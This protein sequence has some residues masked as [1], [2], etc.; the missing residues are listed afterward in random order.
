MLGYIWMKRLRLFGRHH[1]KGKPFPFV[2]VFS[3]LLNLHGGLAP[4]S[5]FLALACVDTITNQAKTNM[6]TQNQHKLTPGVEIQ[7]SFTSW[8]VAASIALA[9][10]TMPAIG[11]D[12]N[13]AR[14]DHDAIRPFHVKVPESQ[15]TELRRRIKA[16]KWPEKE[17]VGD[18]SQGVQLATM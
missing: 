2:S 14:T 9:A 12:A 17:T 6:K 8:R 18:A 16:T 5:G 1:L 3:Q 11:G 15:L 10:A 13:G 7:R 4:G